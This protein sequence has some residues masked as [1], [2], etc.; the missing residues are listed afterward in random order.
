MQRRVVIDARDRIRAMAVVLQTGWERGV[1]L[2]SQMLGKVKLS[3]KSITLIPAFR[4]S[5]CAAIGSSAAVKPE[6]PV[7]V[8]FGSRSRAGAHNEDVAGTLPELRI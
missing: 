8:G 5:G 2:W 6:M 7:A 3:V 4:K 1:P